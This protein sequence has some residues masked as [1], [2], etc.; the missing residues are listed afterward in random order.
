[1]SED[2]PKL[3]GPYLIRE[4][5]KRETE[6]KE[7]EGGKREI[8]DSAERLLFGLWNPADWEVKKVVRNQNLCR[9]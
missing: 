5:C 4:G 2:S 1:M 7:R 9:S 8:R 6:V 3:L